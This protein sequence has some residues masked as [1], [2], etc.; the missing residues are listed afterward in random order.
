MIQGLDLSNYLQ[1]LFSWLIQPTQNVSTLRTKCIVMHR[2][3]TNS[4]IPRVD[5]QFFLERKL[6]FYF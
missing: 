1:I 6:Q 5:L 3:D 2:F 4:N